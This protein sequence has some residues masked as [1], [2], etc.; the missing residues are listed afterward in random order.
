M[1]EDNI[2]KLLQRH[3]EGN[4]TPEEKEMVETWYLNEI[5]SNDDELHVN[6]YDEVQNELWKRIKSERFI[7]TTRFSW[8]KRN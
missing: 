1:K 8:L 2:K 4:C 6:N 5:S 7:E 3:I